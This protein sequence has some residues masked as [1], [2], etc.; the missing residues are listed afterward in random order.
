[1][2]RFLSI[3]ALVLLVVLA[4]GCKKAPKTYSIVG[5]WELSEVSTKAVNYDGVKVSVYLTFTDTDFTLYQLIGNGH[6]KKF[7]GTYTYAEGKLQGKYSSGSS[8]GSVYNVQI[9]D[10]KLELATA[11][12][13]EVDVYKKISA[14]PADVIADVLE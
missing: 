5:S 9:D 8:L 12:G 10:T 6:Y 3:A 1:M 2:K 11:G 7:N 13:K 4:A 14:V